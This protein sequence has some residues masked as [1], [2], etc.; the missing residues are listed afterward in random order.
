[1]ET[2]QRELRSLFAHGCHAD[3]N[4]LISELPYLKSDTLP[5]SCLIWN[6][7]SSINWLLLWGFNFHRPDCF[8]WLE[9]VRI[10][11]EQGCPADILQIKVEHDHALQAD[12]TAG[13]GW[14]SILESIQVGLDGTQ[15]DSVN[16]G[17]FHQHLRVVDT[18][19]A[20]QNL[21]TAHEKV[22]R[23]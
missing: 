6:F 11:R 16:L 21:F 22:I 14:A 20:R 1:M 10:T 3:T 17:A 15:L 18:L 2:A 4:L 7:L 23:V 12:T 13:M 8:L 9:T 5:V 19:S